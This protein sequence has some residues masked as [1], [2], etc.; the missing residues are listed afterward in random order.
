MIA[1]GRIRAPAWT[2][3]IADTAIQC[4]VLRSGL[5][6]LPADVDLGWQDGLGSDLRAAMK[7]RFVLVEYR[8]GLRFYRARP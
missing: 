7:R 2:D 1:A 8:A 3:T 4:A 5:L 6:E